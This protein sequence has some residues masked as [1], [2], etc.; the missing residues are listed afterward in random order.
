MRVVTATE[1]KAKCPAF[2]AE[3]EKRG[4]PITITKRGRPVAVV[5]PPKKKAWKSPAGSLAGK[6]QIV[7]DI[8]NTSMADLWEC[9][10]EERR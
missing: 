4:E 9:A 8:V 10:R 1:F 3:V 6:I 7:G 5:S 2:L